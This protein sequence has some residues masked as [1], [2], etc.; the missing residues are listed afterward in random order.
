MPATNTPSVEPFTLPSPTDALLLSG[1]FLS[2]KDPKAV[3]QLSHGMSE[4]KE[5]Y[6][7][8]MNFLAQH[9][10]A[11]VIHDHR[12]HGASLHQ[13]DP[14]ALG[15]MGDNGAQAIVEDL[16]AVSKLAKERWPGLPL[17][18]FGHSMGSLVVRCYSQK[19]DR[20]LAGLIV[21][22]SPSNNP[23][24]G[25][26]KALAKLLTLFYGER[27]RSSLVQKMAFGSY[28]RGIELP[29]SPN[30]WICANPQTVSDYDRDP[31]CG[32]VFTLNGFTALFTLVQQ[33]YRPQ[34]WQVSNPQMPVLFIAGADDPCILSPQKFQQAVDL[35]KSVGYA[36]VNAILYPQMRHEL[37]NETESGKVMED[38][39]DFL[40]KSL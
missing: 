25:P 21:C 32:F 28:N 31:L 16:Y 4:H 8:F 35:V 39:L 23:G 40:E 18:L 19:Y 38:V 27:H 10:Y 24:A 26:G 1:L 14:D 30:S 20:E 36:H 13:G 6:L 22:G 33:V 2:P 7:P 3:V 17:F 29:E 34:N 15:Y 5:R 12:G 37:L 9:G 11:S